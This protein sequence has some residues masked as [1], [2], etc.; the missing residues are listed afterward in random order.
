MELGLL[1]YGRSV[2]GAAEPALVSNV[3][4]LAALAVLAVLA[5]TCFHVA[6]PL[7]IRAVLTTLARERSSA[8]E[9]YWDY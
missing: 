9:C 6:P 1:G 3:V 2:G 5:P 8:D 4:M 7:L